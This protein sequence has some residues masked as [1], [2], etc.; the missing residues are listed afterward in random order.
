MGLPA[1]IF[2]PK[3]APIGKLTQ[4][5]LYGA[6]LVVVDG[7]Y[8]AA[9]ILSKEAIDKFYNMVKPVNGNRW[10]DFDPV[11]SKTVELLRVVPP[12]TQKAAAEN[13]KKVLKEM[14]IDHE[15]LHITD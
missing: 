7:D 11:I 3:R 5:S 9:F 4:I 8:K 1:V 13:F 6:T 2:V 10:Y 14:G 12:D 15:I